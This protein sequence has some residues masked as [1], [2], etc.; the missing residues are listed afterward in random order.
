MFCSHVVCVFRMCMSSVLQL[1][2]LLCVLFGKF[3]I[4]LRHP[5]CRKQKLYG[6]NLVLHQYL[7]SWVL[8]CLD[9]EKWFYSCR[10]DHIR[11]PIFKH[12]Q[13]CA[14]VGRAASTVHPRIWK[15]HTNQIC[16][17]WCQFPEYI[18]TAWAH[19]LPEVGKLKSHL[20][21]GI[22]T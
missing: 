17:T 15:Q 16:F 1:C 10:A 13:R 5:I 11:S 21:K 7:F 22:W 9:K 12:S 19:F 6:E 18:V 20:H 14:L 8:H 3:T 2:H 4:Q